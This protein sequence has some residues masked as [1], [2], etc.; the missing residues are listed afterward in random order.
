MMDLPIAYKVCPNLKRIGKA[1]DGGYVVCTC[2][3]K[4]TDVLVS[5]GVSDDWSFEKQSARFAGI[6]VIYA[7]DFSVSFLHFLEE[8]IMSIPKFI[9]RRID[10]NLFWATFTLP[11][12]YRIFFRKS[13]FHFALRVNNHKSSN[14]DTTVDDIFAKT[15]S[16]NIFVKIDIEGFEYKILHDLLKY[17]YR[18][19][20]LVIEFHDT[21]FLKDKFRSALQLISSEFDT[22]HAHGNNFEG[23]DPSSELPEVLEVSFVRKSR[24]PD[25][26]F[27]ASFPTPG[28]DQP[29][30]KRRK[31]LV[32]T[33]NFI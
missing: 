17:S 3:L 23:V 14:F 9:L 7:Y 15:N 30:D 16:S 22:V 21:T 32:F 18:I 20:A 8:S 1:N 33:V 10:K 2:A 25:R 13:F 12:R 19:E 11:I 29:N 26:I 6:D 4:E 5:M 24:H 27:V 31:D 28:L